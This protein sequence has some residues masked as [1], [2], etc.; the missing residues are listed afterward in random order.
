MPDNELRYEVPYKVPTL[1]PYADIRI[2]Q[3]GPHCGWRADYLRAD[4][5]LLESWAYHPEWAASYVRNYP[6]PIDTWLCQSIRLE[7]PDPDAP[8]PI[9]IAVYT[10]GIP[11]LPFQLTDGSTGAGL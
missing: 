2:T 3:A 4:G 8:E 10:A 1:L 11:Y 7:W 5:V 9:A 6:G